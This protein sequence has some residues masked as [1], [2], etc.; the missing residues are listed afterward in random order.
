MDSHPPLNPRPPTAAPG[1]RN[2]M[3]VTAAL[4]AVT[5]ASEAA[6]AAPPPGMI[7]LN[8]SVLSELQM[9]GLR[10]I[11]QLSK[12]RRSEQPLKSL[13]LSD[14]P[15]KQL[16]PIDRI[17]PPPRLQEIEKARQTV[18]ERIKANRYNR[19]N[20]RAAL[21][22]SLNSEPYMTQQGDVQ[23][24][25]PQC[26]RPETVRSARLRSESHGEVGAVLGRDW[27]GFQKSNELKNIGRLGGGKSR[28]NVRRRTVK[29][30]R[31]L[32]RNKHRRA[33]IR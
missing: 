29:R 6:T 12:K 4:P 10:A 20:D 25:M 3:S 2:L 26:R 28:K 31:R 18:R 21:L 13:W 5:A 16:S 1:R 19:E 32:T 33:N 15:P 27:M 9:H 14:Q 30:K 23:V 17:S 22:E 11:Q 7:R 24:I 8:K